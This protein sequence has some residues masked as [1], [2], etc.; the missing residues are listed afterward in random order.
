MQQFMQN[1]LPVALQS[2]WIT[3]NIRRQDQSHVVLRNNDEL[4][5]PLAISS[6]TS[7]H[8]LTTFSQLWA[9]FPEESIKFIRNKL[10]FN[11]KLK[12]HLLNQLKTQ[13]TCGRLLCPDC[14]LNALLWQKNLFN[15]DNQSC[16]CTGTY[17]RSGSSI[18]FYSLLY[19][20]H[21]FNNN[22]Y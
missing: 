15:F 8:P 13:V 10:E 4:H 9:D 5:I 22:I 12:N 20:F 19:L 11:S 18:L 1:F 3:N 17:T 16:Y 7:K 14:H 21:F 2:M 6:F